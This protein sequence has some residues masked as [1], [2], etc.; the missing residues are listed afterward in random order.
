MLKTKLPKWL[1]KIGTCGKK[2]FTYAIPKVPSSSVLFRQM[3][4]FEALVDEIRGAP[5]VAKLLKRSRVDNPEN[6][7]SSVRSKVGSAIWLVLSQYF[8]RCSSDFNVALITEVCHG[9]RSF[10]NPAGCWIE[11][12]FK[13]SIILL[14]SNKLLYI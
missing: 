9:A 14:L 7:T 5:E 3:P 13:V 4:S 12:V 10:K 1:N 11:E 8:L 6:F 2:R